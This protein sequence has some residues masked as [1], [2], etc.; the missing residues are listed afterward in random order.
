MSCLSAS[1][2][3]VPPW[4]NG[5]SINGIVTNAYRQVH[6]LYETIAPKRNCIIAV[7][8]AYRQVHLLY[9]FFSSHFNCQE[10]RSQMPIGKYIFCTWTIKSNY[11]HSIG[12]KCLSASTF[13]VPVEISI[14]T[15]GDASQM[16]IG[17]YIYCTHKPRK[18]SIQPTSHKCLSA[19]TFTVLGIWLRRSDTRGHKCLSASTF[20]VP[21]RITNGQFLER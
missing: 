4:E 16:P 15:S 7:T 1:T 3:T 20:T 6:L 17:K 18:H 12:H 21:V 13:T 5:V 14:M 11:L 8:N 2:F 9:L 19:S 10:N